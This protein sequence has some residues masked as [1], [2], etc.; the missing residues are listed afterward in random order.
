MEAIVI[1]QEGRELPLLQSRL[2]KIG[3]SGSDD[4]FILHDQVGANHAQLIY[5]NKL[6]AW[7]IELIG[8][9]TPQDKQSPERRKALT[10]ED[11]A[12]KYNVDILLRKDQKDGDVVIP[13]GDAKQMLP[14]AQAKRMAFVKR[15]NQ[16]VPLELKVTYPLQNNDVIVLGDTEGGYRILYKESENPFPKQTHPPEPYGEAI[17][18]KEVEKSSKDG[19]A[20]PTILPQPIGY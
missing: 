13:M 3:S 16:Y 10:P 17:R 20:V 18:R 1:S 2:Y 5:D 4:I 19:E 9:I 11:I 12:R 6:S 15:A 14:K 8:S 7:N